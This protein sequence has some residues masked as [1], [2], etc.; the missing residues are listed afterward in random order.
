[1]FQMGH[2]IPEWVVADLVTHLRSSTGR[3]P[4]K[5]LAIKLIPLARA[6]YS[7][8]EMSATLGVS[9]AHIGRAMAFLKS[10]A[11]CWVQS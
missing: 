1:M 11:R 3:G 7:R 6:G 4:E 8:A 2:D 9:K 5:R 10:Q